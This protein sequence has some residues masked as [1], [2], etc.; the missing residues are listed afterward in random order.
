[1]DLVMLVVAADEGIMPQTR[2]HMDIL[3][4]LG[5]EKSILVLNKCDLVEEDW[6]ELVKEEIKEELEGTF[7]EQ[8]PIVEVSAA[9]GQGIPELIEVI[10][11][12]TAEEVVEKD[13]NTIPRLPIDRVFS[14]SGFG[15]IIT[16]TLLAGMISKE[17][18]LQVYPI[19]KECKIRNIQVHGQDVELSLIHI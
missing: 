15:T 9:T 5:I 6:L 17:D 19:G 11:R 12:L 10:E 13:V 4:E 3:G 1:M 2:E 8:A 14:L 18:N 16:G 7:L